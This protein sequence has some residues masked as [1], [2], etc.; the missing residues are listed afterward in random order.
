MNQSAARERQSHAAPVTQQQGHAELVFHAANAL[1]R[2]GQGHVGAFGTPRDGSRL[3]DVQ[4]KA[5]VGE[6]EAHAAN[7]SHSPQAH[8]EA[9]FVD[10]EFS[11][12]GRITRMEG[13]RPI[14]H[15]A[16]TSRRI[17]LGQ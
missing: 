3:V 15:P 16:I 10:S 17:A 1:A 4:E 6:I 13:I 11:S 9:G 14:R 12:M 2:R 7:V 8:P 5:H